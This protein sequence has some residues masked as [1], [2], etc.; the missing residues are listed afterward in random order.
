[1]KE[2]TTWLIRFTAALIFLAGGSLL[3]V[4]F[5]LT[6][7][8]SGFGTHTQLGLPPCWFRVWIGLP[9]PT[10]G[11]TTSLTHLLQGNLSA[12]LQAHLLGPLVHTL[13]CVIV[14]ISLA[15]CWRPGLTSRIFHSH[16]VRVVVD[17]ALI[18]LVITWIYEV[19]N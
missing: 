17:F 9:C 19:L 5:F 1:M 13:L 14:L 16:A 3:V 11:L 15:I 10:C 8:V 6:P 7:A 12:A 18:L 4:P 2:R